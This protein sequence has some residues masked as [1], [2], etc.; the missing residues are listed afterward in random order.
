MH[1]RS[2]CLEGLDSFDERLSELGV[3]LQGVVEV[4]HVEVSVL[5][6][7]EVDSVEHPKE[8]HLVVPATERR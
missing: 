4:I 3:E 1:L 6:L 8:G 7:V 5:V 2:A